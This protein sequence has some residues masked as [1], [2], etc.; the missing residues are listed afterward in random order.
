[1]KELSAD[2]TGDGKEEL[3][4]ELS[5]QT[6]HQYAVIFSPWMYFETH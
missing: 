1:M 2:I 4:F 5:P 6:S 3:G